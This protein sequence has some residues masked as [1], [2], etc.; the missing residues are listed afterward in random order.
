MFN[1]PALYQKLRDLGVYRFEVTA[2]ADAMNQAGAHTVSRL[3][4]R[5]PNATDD[6]VREYVLA[7]MKAVEQGDYVP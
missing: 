2:L 5:A 3:L 4:Q 7:A 6:E 1:D